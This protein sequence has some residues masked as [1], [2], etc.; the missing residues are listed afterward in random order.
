M[1]TWQIVLIAIGAAIIVITAAVCGVML[2]T[3][4]QRKK[5]ELAL[6]KVTAKLNRFAGIR[7]FKVLSNVTLQTDKKEFWLAAKRREPH[8]WGKTPFK[9][10]PYENRLFHCRSS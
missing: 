2:Y 5:G 6:N 7:S 4:Q 1:Q 3:S 9:Q 8:F 10:C